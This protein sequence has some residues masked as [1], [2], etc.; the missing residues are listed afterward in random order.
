MST[1]HLVDPELL[2][3]LEVFPSFEF[4]LEQLPLIR[5]QAKAMGAASAPISRRGV[6]VCERHVPGPADGPAVRVLIYAPAAAATARPALLHIH[7]GG[8]VVGAPEMDDGRN[9]ALA[10]ELDCVVVSVDYRLPPEFPFPAPIEDCHAVLTWLFRQASELGVDPKRIGVYGE[11]AGGGLAAA[12][13]LLARDRESVP[14]AFQLLIYPMLDDRTCVVDPH[15]LVG[16]FIWPRPA[17]AFG[18]RCLLGQAPGAKGVSAYASA[19]RASSLAG[20]PPTFIGVGALDLFLDENIDY[21]RRL[22]QAGVPTELHVYPGAYHGFEM[23]APEARVS[24][25]FERDLRHALRKALVA[26]PEASSGEPA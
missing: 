26:A 1:R 16:E 3:L 20:L 6:T 10:A 7:G 11:S 19:A 12:L 17:N 13:A 18:W 22:T 15:P 8:Y 2:P 5:E 9:K 25:Q 23:L 4:S 21:A 24:R 14:I